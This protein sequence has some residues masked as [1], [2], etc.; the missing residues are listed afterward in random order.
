MV[1][2]EKPKRRARGFPSPT[3]PPSR[4]NS[5]VPDPWHCHSSFQ[6]TDSE[7]TNH[8]HIQTFANNRTRK[9]QTGTLSAPTLDWTES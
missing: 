9:N 6:G 2:V 1:Y 5:P 8:K 3:I 7:A 4:L